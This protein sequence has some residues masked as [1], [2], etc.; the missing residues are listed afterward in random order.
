MGASCP[1]LLAAGY[2]AKDSCIYEPVAISRMPI[3]VYFTAADGTKYHVYETTFTGGKHHRR[4]IGDSTATL[5]VFVLKDRAQ[6]RRSY[7]CKSPA[8]V[9]DEPPLERQLR[10]ATYIGKPADARERRPR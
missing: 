8:R 6:M 3:E 7:T 2:V 9:L 5:R 4:A 10:E 1:S